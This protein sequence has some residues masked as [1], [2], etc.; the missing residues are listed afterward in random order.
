MQLRASEAHLAL[1]LA[2]NNLECAA[3]Y[4]LQL[5]EQ[6]A[7]AFQELFAQRADE[8]QMLGYA[9]AV[10]HLVALSSVESE[11]RRVNDEPPDQGASESKHQTQI[12]D[13][14]FWIC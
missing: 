10:G 11:K 4:T 3:R 5:G 12:F 13:S 1:P 8:R 2:L 9:T 7:A 6:L 14:S